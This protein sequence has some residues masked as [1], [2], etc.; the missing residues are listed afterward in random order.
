M[1]SNFTTDG[2]GTNSFVLE[3]PSLL[4]LSNTPLPSSIA[5]AP[6]TING[7][8]GNDTVYFVGSNLGHVVINEPD[9]DTDDLTL[10]FSNFQGGPTTLNLTLTS[11][12]TVSPDQLYLTCRA[13][14]TLPM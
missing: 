8:G 7:S 5:D 10:D 3:D 1:L 13:N 14:R 9:G 11:E 4:G 2:S 12:Q 6:T